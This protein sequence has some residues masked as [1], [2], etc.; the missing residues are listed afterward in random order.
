MKFSALNEWSL[1]LTDQDVVQ[2][3]KKIPGY[4][5][6]TPS[7]FMEV[8][9]A[10]FSH[11]LSRIKNAIRADQIMTQPVIAVHEDTSLLEVVKKM[12]VHGISGLPVLK[13]D[14]TISGVI[15][16]KDVIQ[17]MNGETLT[18]FMGVLLQC[19]ENKRCLAADIQA[20]VASDIMSYPPI[21]VQRETPILEVANTM[22]QFSINRVPVIDQEKKSVGIIA[23]SDLVK[24]IS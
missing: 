3:M 1:A 23:R 7:D 16:G 13:P 12:A 21:I 9:R 8:Y 11:A 6:I 10:A 22:D 5:D 17:R 24:A 14:Q 2:A 4:L 18:S 20:L 19:L 15:S